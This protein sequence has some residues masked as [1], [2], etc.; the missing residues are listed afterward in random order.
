[1]SRRKWFRVYHGLPDDVALAV[2]ARQA[3]FSRAEMLA[4][5]LTLL[6]HASRHEQPGSLAGLDADTLS[7][8]LGLEAERIAAGLAALKARKRVD[9]HQ[10]I[11]GW[12][13]YQSS[14]TRRVRN[15]RARR[16]SAAAP[17]PPVKALG[18][19]GTPSTA[20]TPDSP[21]AIAARRARLQHNN[22]LIIGATA[23]DNR[24]A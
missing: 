5:W 14:S 22:R 19:P 17:T 9:S 1:M 4:L 7:L 18:R 3:G 15:L 13:R 2:A 21:A 12:D 20:P 8:Q 23:R 10:R 11:V 16:S 24:H 6:D